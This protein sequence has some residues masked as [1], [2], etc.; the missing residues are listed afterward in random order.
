[1]DLWKENNLSD[2][3]NLLEFV[4]SIWQDNGGYSFTHKNTIAYN[5]LLSSIKRNELNRLA[6]HKTLTEMKA[7]SKN[8]LDEF[9]DTYYRIK[10]ELDSKKPLKA[11]WTFFIPIEAEFENTLTILSQLL[12]L[13]TNIN[14]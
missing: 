4:L 9:G 6:A 3:Q 5:E 10:K 11:K 1:M 14:L 13:E 7:N 12:Y 2:L 8:K